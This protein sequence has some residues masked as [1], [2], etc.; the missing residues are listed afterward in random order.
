MVSLGSWVKNRVQQMS[1]FQGQA[2]V[3]DWLDLIRGKPPPSDFWAQA[4]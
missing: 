2:R 1:L 3:M 4:V